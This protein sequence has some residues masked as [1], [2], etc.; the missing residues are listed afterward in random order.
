MEVICV[1]WAIFLDLICS[2]LAFSGCTAK[3]DTAQRPSTGR[4]DRQLRA[5]KS[6]LIVEKHELSI[7]QVNDLESEEVKEKRNKH[8]VIVIYNS[9]LM[10]RH[11]LKFSEPFKNI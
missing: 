11:Y 3:R 1:F 6:T 2:L 7:G 9:N 8:D 4:L 5:E 10:S